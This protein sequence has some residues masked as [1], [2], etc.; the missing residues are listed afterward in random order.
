MLWV[1]HLWNGLWLLDD[2]VSPEGQ[3]SPG[4]VVILNVNSFRNKQVTLVSSKRFVRRVLASRNQCDYSKVSDLKTTHTHMFWQLYFYV[5]CLFFLSEWT[6]LN[7]LVAAI[8][9][10]LDLK[11]GVCQTFMF[12]IASTHYSI[13]KKTVKLHF[14]NMWKCSPRVW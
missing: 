1:S 8:V 5:L 4:Q 13:Q 2:Y 6:W 11:F 7:I 12:F 9:V 10:Q 3:K 14:M